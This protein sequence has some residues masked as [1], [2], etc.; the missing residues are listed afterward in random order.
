MDQNELRK[1][2]GVDRLLE[3]RE[4][5]GC[6]SEISQPIAAE[7]IRNLLDTLRGEVAES[8]KCPE[9]EAIVGRV[10]TA[11]LDLKN[12]FLREAINATGVIIHTNL[13]RAPLG[14]EVIEKT[15]LAAGSYSNLEYDLARGERGFRGSLQESLIATLT[16]C[17]EVVVVNNCASAVF[18]VLSMYAKGREVVISRG[19]LVQIGGGFRVP[20]ILEQSGASLREVGSTNQTSITDYRE[21][22]C[23]KTALILKVHHSNFLMQGFVASADENELASLSRKRGMPFVYDLGSGAVYDTEKYG[24]KHEPTVQDAL[25]SGADIVCFSGDKLLGGP[26]AGIIAGGKNGLRP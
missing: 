2:P 6:V 4:V 22:M 18:L 15:A 9:F 11:L 24:L 19:E 21:A 23:E 1:I 14:R 20:E 5:A 13:G 17:E 8:G 26:Q 16:G 3:T 25:R 12:L 7:V 10:C